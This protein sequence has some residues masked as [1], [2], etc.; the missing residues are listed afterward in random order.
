MET[1]NIQKGNNPTKEHKGVQAHQF[2]QVFNATG[3][4]PVRGLYKNVY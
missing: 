3:N 2:H 4:S 1:G